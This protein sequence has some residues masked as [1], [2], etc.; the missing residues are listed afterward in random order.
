MQCCNIILIILYQIGEFAGAS[1]R[2][3]AFIPPEVSPPT[4]PPP[5]QQCI[6]KKIEFTYIQGDILIG[7][8]LDEP[9][10]QKIFH[11]FLS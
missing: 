4:C 6:Q 1:L 9:N 5:C 3:Q 7:G 2:L 11:N 10:F 8:E